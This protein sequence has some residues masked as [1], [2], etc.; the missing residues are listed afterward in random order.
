VFALAQRV[1]DVAST[2]TALEHGPTQK[3]LGWLPFGALAQAGLSARDGDW[4]AVLARTVIVAAALV[5][6]LW[7]WARAL[8]ARVQ[9]RAVGLRPR[10][11]PAA[12]TEMDLVPPPLS[13]LTAGA[14][15][16]AAAQQ[17]RYYF[18]R[19]PQALQGGIF[20]LVIAVFVAHTMVQP[21]D[22]GLA[23][24]GLAAFG[25]AV[26]TL[27]LD[28]LAYDHRGFTFLVWSGAPMRRVLAG[29]VL[30][31]V[32]PMTGLLVV[33]LVVEATIADAWTSVFPSLML[34][35]GVLLLASGVG[36]VASVLAPHNRVNRRFNKGAALLSVFAGL[37]AVLVVAAVAVLVAQVL[38]GVVGSL[39]SSIGVLAL[40]VAGAWGGLGWAGRRLERSQLRVL[41]AL[42]L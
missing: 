14:G 3:V 29:K 30:V 13:A 36:A 41:E 27:F 10:S 31:A 35:I 11:R 28:V 18:F 20:P 12:A 25:G 40:G 21:A 5:V 33:F 16:G 1:T 17:L 32:L 4:T 19:S 8:G 22:L 24:V 15:V 37:A 26:T 23:A 6:V 39:A 42:G 34:G 38:T 9:G 7:I 2:L